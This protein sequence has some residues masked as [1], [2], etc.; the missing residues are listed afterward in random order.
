MPEHIDHD[1]SRSRPSKV[2]IDTVI[3]TIAARPGSSEGV[4]YEVMKH[5][6]TTLCDYIETKLLN[7]RGVVFPNFVRVVLKRV[8]SDSLLWGTRTVFVP[9]LTF[10]QSF[11]ERFLLESQRQRAPAT[12]VD[13]TVLVNYCSIATSSGMSKDV[14]INTLK[15]VT[16]RI[17]EM[18]N[19]GIRFSVDFGFC[20]VLFSGRKYV[21]QWNTAFTEKVDEMGRDINNTHM[22]ESVWE[23]HD[24]YSSVSGTTR[25]N[26]VHVD[27]QKVVLFQRSQQ[28]KPRH[29][30][31]TPTSEPP[32]GM[33]DRLGTP[34]L[35]PSRPSSASTSRSSRHKAARPQPPSHTE[36]SPVDALLREVHSRPGSAHSRDSLSYPLRPKRITPVF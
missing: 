34:S 21:V 20:R 32:L 4:T 16:R 3:R 13:T 18:A 2:T 24:K 35:Q 7:N 10:H 31:S 14:V 6:W 8:T 17:G 9:T 28:K 23:S 36:P 15:D 12:K 29:R 5:V 30:M 33:S 11:V 1:S 27:L 19:R 26:D 25:V 22:K